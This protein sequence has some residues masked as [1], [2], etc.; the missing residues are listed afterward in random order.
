MKKELELECGNVAEAT[1]IERE[2]GTRE[3]RTKD[4]LAL[5]YM[6]NSSRTGL[7]SIL[8]I[9]SPLSSPDQEKNRLLGGLF[10]SLKGDKRI[11]IFVFFVRIKM[12]PLDFFPFALV[13]FRKKSISL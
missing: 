13:V 5:Q 9:H 1:E 4:I 7:V 3:V 11:R 10:Y 6:Y 2:L 12:L 8:V